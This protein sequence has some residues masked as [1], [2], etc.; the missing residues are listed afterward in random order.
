MEKLK[1]LEYIDELLESTL[2]DELLE[3]LEKIGYIM[4][5]NGVSEG[6]WIID[7]LIEYVEEH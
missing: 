4:R 1:S 3:I 5:D 2:Q 6:G 7:D